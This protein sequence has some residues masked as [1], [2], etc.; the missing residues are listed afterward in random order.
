MGTPEPDDLMDQAA[1]FAA[2]LPRWTGS[3]GLPLSWPHFVVG[4]RHLGRA[5]NTTTLGQAAA[6][7]AGMAST[8]DYSDW[9]NDL[10]AS[11]A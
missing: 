2:E 5:A 8:R 3:D 11:G 7:R 1:Q 6:V 9:R 4:M 10:K